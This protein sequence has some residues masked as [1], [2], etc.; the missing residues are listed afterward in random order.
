MR[1]QHDTGSRLPYA[2]RHRHRRRFL[3]KY[4]DTIETII[5]ARVS[6]YDSWVN[7]N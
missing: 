4:L 5:F 3:S 1:K 7:I 6:I 2:R